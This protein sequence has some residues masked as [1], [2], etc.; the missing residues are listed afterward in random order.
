MHHN[1][2]TEYRNDSIATKV[3][4]ILALITRINENIKFD[5]TTTNK[6]TLTVNNKE[7]IFHTYGEVINALKLVL[8]LKENGGDNM[9]KTIKSNFQGVCPICNETG[10]LKYDTPVFDDYGLYFPWEC[11]N[12]NSTGNEEYSMEFDGHTKIYNSKGEKIEDYEK[13]DY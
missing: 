2:R 9:Q 10:T 1:I 4:T 8:L 13:S 3:N 6:F 5:N 7:L 11:E 12:C